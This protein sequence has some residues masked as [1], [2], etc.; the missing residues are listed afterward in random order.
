[1]WQTIISIDKKYLRKIHQIVSAMVAGLHLIMTNLPAR[2]W[3]NN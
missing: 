2:S 3:K 1:M